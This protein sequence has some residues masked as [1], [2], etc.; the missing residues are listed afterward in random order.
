MKYLPCLTILCLVAGCASESS[1]GQ[2]AAPADP[3][4]AE[5]ADL[6]LKIGARQQDL[7]QANTDLAKIATERDQV[8]GQPASEAKTN[9][10]IELQRLENDAKQR[11]AADTEEIAQLQ[12]RLNGPSDAP[13]A[14]P[15]KPATSNDALDDILAAND[16]KEKDEAERKKKKADDDAA[17]DQQRLAQAEAAR[18]AELDERSK[19][20]IEGG[21]LAAGPD[22]PAFED[23]WADVIQKIQAELQK[24]KR[25]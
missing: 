19:Q 2:P 11:K 21:R 23:R 15:A 22:A 20:K 4:A 8:A 14:A 24:Y 7:D 17:A 16:K 3:R 13:A 1:E 9:R 10:L 25:W 5:K 6:R 12:Q 18:K